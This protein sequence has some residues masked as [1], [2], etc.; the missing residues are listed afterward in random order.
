[1]KPIVKH[2]VKTAQGVYPA[3]RLLRWA[4]VLVGG[5]LWRSYR[6]RQQTKKN[7]A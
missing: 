1:V 6:K 2:A 4:L 3:Y 5:A 7:R